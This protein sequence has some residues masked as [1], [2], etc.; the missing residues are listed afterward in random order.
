MREMRAIAFV[1]RLLDEGSL[2]GKRYAKMLIHSIRNDAE[3]AQHS[4]ASKF[5]A[6]WDFLC[7][8]KDQGRIAAG[9]WLA[10]SY[11]K[12]GNESSIDLAATFL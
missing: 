10:E 1:T 11:G 2:D 4:A 9:A 12:V 3:M 6:D 5:N 7:H 8:L